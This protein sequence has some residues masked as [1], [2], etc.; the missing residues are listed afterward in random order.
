MSEQF[1]EA[2]EREPLSFSSE[3]AIASVVESVYLQ[4]SVYHDVEDEN[5]VSLKV[6]GRT[7]C[8]QKPKF[9]R[10]DTT[11][12]PLDPEL[13]VKGM[14]KEVSALDSLGVSDL[15][16]KEQAE[17]FARTHNV[18]ILSTRWVAV[19]KRDGETKEQI[20]RARIVV[21]DYASGGPTAK[22]LGISS[23]TSSNEVFRTFLIFVSSHGGD[24]V[25]ADVSTAFL[26]AEVVSP[27]VVMLPPNIRYPDNSRVYMELRKA[28]YGL[29]SASL[30]WYRMLAD[31]VESLGL[32]A[33]E[34]EKTVFTGWF[35]FEGDQFYIVL[36]GDVDDLMIGCLSTAAAKHFVS[37]LAQKVKSQDQDN[38]H[39]VS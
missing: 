27:E 2:V 4:A 37:L 18:K 14:C 3:Q 21:R 32:K 26:F 8:L 5:W 30:A 33:C 31:M 22:E 23:P 9:L 19:D 15:V 38:G 17:L 11:G 24:I 34:T 13:T 36:L 39:L 29:R 10:D 7:V 25:L 6:R 12:K 28:L 35:R 16:E 1:V 20:V